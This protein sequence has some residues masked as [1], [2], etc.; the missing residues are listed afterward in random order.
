[1]EPPKSILGTNT[2]HC[3]FTSG[4]LPEPQKPLSA[5]V[6]T[7]WN[8]VWIYLTEEA[9][10]PLFLVTAPLLHD[11]SERTS[12]KCTGRCC[13]TSWLKQTN[14]FS[15]KGQKKINTWSQDL[16]TKLFDVC[17]FSAWQYAWEKLKLC[18]L[19]AFLFEQA[20]G[21]NVCVLAPC[22]LFVW[23]WHQAFT[24]EYSF[25]LLDSISN[26]LWNDFK[27]LYVYIQSNTRICKEGL[28][29]TWMNN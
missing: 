15:Q 24:C 6:Q 29:S 19:T 23:P 21:V 18:I 14:S 20:D 27:A 8:K 25:A 13:L 3:H 9:F 28:E 22:C 17:P 12:W 16:K 2:Y 7:N 5:A 11:L 4:W 26:Y 1:M 10:S